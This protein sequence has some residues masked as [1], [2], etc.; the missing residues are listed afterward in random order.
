MYGILCPSRG[1]SVPC[2]SFFSSLSLFLEN[3]VYG[4]FL[5]LFQPFFPS[6]PLL[7]QIIFQR[8]CGNKYLFGHP[9]KKIIFQ[10]Q[11][12]YFL[13]KRVLVLLICNLS[14]VCS[15]HLCCRCGK[16]LTTMPPDSAP[17]NPQWAPPPAPT[18]ARRRSSPRSTSSTSSLRCKLYVYPDLPAMNVGRASTI[19]DHPRSSSMHSS[20][21]HSILPSKIVVSMFYD[22]DLCS[23]F[24]FIIVRN[25]FLSVHQ[26]KHVNN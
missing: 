26:L 15:D 7:K 23:K 10:R 4:L 8:E 24:G 17:R 5:K 16:T 25:V 18:S 9:L 22:L 11:R 3:H 21:M 2:A 12:V 14:R 20:S 1:P 6:T 13:N 19:Y